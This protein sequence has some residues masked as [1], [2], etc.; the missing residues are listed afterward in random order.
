M[1]KISQLYIYPIKSL[2]GISVK[3]SK[4]TDRGLEY[5]RRWML[6]DAE[7]KFLTLREYPKMALLLTE[8]TNENL[9]V[10]EKNNPENAIKIPFELKNTVTEK[11]IIWNATVDAVVCGA[12][13]ADWFSTVLGGKCK[14]FY[15]PHTSQRP[16][17]TTSGY[18]PAGKFTSFADAYPFL[19]LGEASMKDLNSRTEAELSILRFRPNIVF[20]GG[21]AYLEDS[22]TE[23][24]INGISFTGLENCARCSIP[25]INPETGEVDTSQQ[26][27]KILAKYRNVNKNIIFGRNVVHTGLGELA[28]GQEL[29]MSQHER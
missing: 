1:L 21:P 26:P 8:I 13:I 10:S 3:K 17:D 19:L 2:A 23:F 12:D 22:I 27:L 4:V 5:D 15:M 16:V 11:V 20:S 25:N 9:I 6:V 29:T 14:L 28:I 24:A 18:H 7:N